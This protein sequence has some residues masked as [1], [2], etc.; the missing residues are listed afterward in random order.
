MAQQHA[1]APAVKLRMETAV[2]ERYA[3][4]QMDVRVHR[5]IP[6]LPVTAG[7]I[8]AFPMVPD[9]TKPG[10]H[11][12][13]PPV[14]VLSTIPRRVLFPAVPAIKRRRVQNQGRVPMGLWAVMEH[15]MCPVVMLTIINLPARHAPR[16]AVPAHI[17]LP[18]I[19]TLHVHPV[20][21]FPYAA[22]GMTRPGMVIA[23]VRQLIQNGRD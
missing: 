4:T 9:V 5:V 23:H 14:D 16:A 11:V 15:V 7:I 3:V 8:N 19:L 10:R 13:V 21:M 17:R 20:R 12:R 22:V 2:A 18:G 1:D 6:R